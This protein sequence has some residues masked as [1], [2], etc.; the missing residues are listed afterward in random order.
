MRLCVGICM[1]CTFIVLCSGDF[2]FEFTA[3]RV[4]APFSPRNDGVVGNASSKW[5]FSGSG[6]S[7][8]SCCI[9]YLHLQRACSHYNPLI[10][11]T[12]PFL[13]VYSEAVR[14]CILQF[15][16]S[17]FPVIGPILCLLQYFSVN[18][19]NILIQ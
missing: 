15:P 6:I 11:L 17:L 1:L 18:D 5:Q 12:I 10:L 2:Y 8:K 14:I 3:V 9:L 16:A 19:D 7:Q 13:C 4:I